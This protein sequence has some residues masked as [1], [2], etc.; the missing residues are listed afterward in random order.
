MGQE[1]KKRGPGAPLPAHIDELL[2]RIGTDP[3]LWEQAKREQ[4]RARQEVEA[5]KARCRV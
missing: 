4:E 5:A 3:E 2:V 1:N